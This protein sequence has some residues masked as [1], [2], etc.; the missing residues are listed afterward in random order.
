[1]RDIFLPSFSS[2]LKPI[3]YFAKI[4]R[5]WVTVQISKS[6]VLRQSPNKRKTVISSWWNKRFQWEARKTVDF[7]KKLLI[8][9]CEILFSHSFR[10]FWNLWNIS[11]KCSVIE[12]L[13]RYPSLTVFHGLLTKGRPLE[14]RHETM[15]SPEDR[16]FEQKTLISLCEIFFSHIFRAFWNLWNVLRKC[17]DIE[18]LYRYRRLTVSNG[19]LTKGRPL[20]ARHETKDFNRKPGRPW[21]WAKKF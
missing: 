12:L 1:M 19:L 16:R 13:Y 14:A 9:L 18:L 10:D 5:Y 11:R 6:D 21:I 3:K 15:G 7:D 8:S 20:E 17:L 4:R 2:F